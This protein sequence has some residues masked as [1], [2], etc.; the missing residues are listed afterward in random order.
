M[1]NISLALVAVQASPSARLSVIHLSPNPNSSERIL[2]KLR[3]NNPHGSSLLRRISSADQKET[4][5]PRGKW[6]YVNKT[7]VQTRIR[8]LDNI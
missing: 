7:L 4:K 6:K 1:E 5:S 3:I 8:C 2:S